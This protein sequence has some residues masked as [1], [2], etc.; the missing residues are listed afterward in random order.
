MSMGLDIAILVIILVTVI[1]GAKRGLVSML[2]N[3]LKLAAS[4]VLAIVFRGKLSEVIM[5][6]KIF[7]G[8][9]TDVT[10][11]LTNAISNAGENLSA[12][13]MLTAFSEK[14][15]QLADILETFGVDFTAVQT[16]L[17]GSTAHS[18]E[19]IASSLAQYII[20]PTAKICSDILAFIAIF[21]AALLG[22]TLLHKILNLV[23]ELPVLHQ[24]NTIG[25]LVAGVVCA[26]LYV[27]LFVT[28]AGLILDNSTMFGFT[29]PENLEADT[30]LYSFFRENSVFAFLKDL[31]SDKTVI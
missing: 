13:E 5:K 15:P 20:E 8:V 4:V 21:V 1:L 18:G 25:G 29:V 31:F 23:F 2:F 12:E 26:Y 11:A 24:I 22:L 28:L 7:E 30:Y 10:E 6:S 3:F 9:K 14:N 27:S 19:N 16:W 17:E